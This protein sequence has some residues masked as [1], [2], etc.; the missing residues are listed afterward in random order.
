MTKRNFLKVFRE[1]VGLALKSKWQG[2][3]ITGS[4]IKRYLRLGYCPFMSINF[5]GKYVIPNC[6][7]RCTPKYILQGHYYQDHR[8]DKELMTQMSNIVATEEDKYG[9]SNRLHSSKRK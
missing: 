6:L 1:H 2:R 9:K 5:F 7:L 8:Q 4:L 3:I